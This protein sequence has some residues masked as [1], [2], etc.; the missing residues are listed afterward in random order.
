M[1]KLINSIMSLGKTKELSPEEIAENIKEVENYL[2]NFPWDLLKEYKEV[3][4]KDYITIFKK[5]RREP[6]GSSILPDMYPSPYNYSHTLRLKADIGKDNKIN[7]RLTHFW[8]YDWWSFEYISKRNE[9]SWEHLNDMSSVIGQS[10]QW[11][12][13]IS[14]YKKNIFTLEKK[15]RNKIRNHK[16]IAPIKNAIGRVLGKK[17]DIAPEKA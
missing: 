13:N 15:L 6:Y 3:K 5:D 7:L 9:N 2:E 12:K 8:N 11:K 16:I 10:L 4:G 1:E 14:N 17:K